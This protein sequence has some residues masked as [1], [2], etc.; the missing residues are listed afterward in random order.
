[1]DPLT[2]VIE[3]SRVRGTVLARVRA[4]APWG[5][6][7]AA[8]AGGTFHAVTAGTCWVRVEGE[9]ARH[10]MPGDVVLMP[11]GTEHALASEAEGAVL[12]FDRVAKE[13]RLTPA[14]TLELAGRGPGT[15]AI[16]AHYDYDH[17]VAQPLLSL[18]PRVLHIPAAHPGDGGGV[19]TTLRL[20]ALELTERPPGSRAVVDRLI[21][22]LFVHVLRAWH[23][24]ADDGRASWLRG[25]RDPTVARALSLLHEQPAGAWTIA[26]LAHEVSVS[27]ATLA[28]R[29]GE[30][31]GEAP[32][33]YLTRWRM[34]LAARRL[35]DTTDPVGAI[36]RDVGYASEYAFSRAFSRLRGQAPGR[37][38]AA[39]QRP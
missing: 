28:R 16:C 22:V 30:L 27:R 32:M 37:Y 35:R 38:R 20:L 7:V 11:T 23:Q 1:M 3:L 10:L 5:I 33:T 26:L 19:Q 34:D 4:H 39:R 36:G 25:L 8:T 6:R 13:R 2:D 29:F 9:P 15:R 12:H 18:L 14:G 21:D 31:V 24:T 17:E